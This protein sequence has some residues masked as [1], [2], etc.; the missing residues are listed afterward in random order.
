MK[1][2]FLFFVSLACVF[3][4]IVVIVIAKLSIVQ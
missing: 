1:G 4:I 3:Y 2:R